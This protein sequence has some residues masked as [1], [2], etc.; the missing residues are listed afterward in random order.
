M[1]SPRRTR[2]VRSAR[3]K[4]DGHLAIVPAH[5]PSMLNESRHAHA[6]RNGCL[7]ST[8]SGRPMSA[9]G[10]QRVYALQSLADRVEALAARQECDS[11]VQRV[12]RLEHVPGRKNQ[13]ATASIV[14]GQPLIVPTASL[15]EDP[16]NPHSEFSEAELEELAEDIRQRG[17]LQ[18]IVVHPVNAAGRHQIHFG[19]KRWRAAQLAELL[20]VSDVVRDAPANPSGA[21][22]REPEAPRLDAARPGAAASMRATRTPPWPSASA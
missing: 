5:D 18:P 22:R 8:N 19:A 9:E 6:H 2:A 13:P 20:E 17:I 1:P 11:I 16:N 15:F 21:S 4:P 10:Q 3:R 14:A 7:A 12:I